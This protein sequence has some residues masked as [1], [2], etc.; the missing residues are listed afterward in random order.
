VFNIVVDF[1][2]NTPIQGK[3]YNLTMTG[4]SPPNNWNCWQVVG[5]STNPV[6]TTV[7]TINSGPWDD[8]PSCPL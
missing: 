6:F 2:V 1:G 5:I 4:Y 8:C 7:Q 3:I